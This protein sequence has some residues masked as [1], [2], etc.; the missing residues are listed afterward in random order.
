MNPRSRQFRRSQFV[1]WVARAGFELTIFRS[2]SSWRRWGQFSRTGG[3]YQKGKIAYED[4]GEG[5]G[6]QKCEITAA[7]FENFDAQDDALGRPRWIQRLSCDSVASARESWLK[8][9]RHRPR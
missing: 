2:D 5:E 1:E 7:R 8:K 4:D 9:P 3:S 6:W